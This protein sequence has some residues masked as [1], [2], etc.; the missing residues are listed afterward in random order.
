MIRVFKVCVFVSGTQQRR[1]PLQRLR[2]P[3][4][5][6]LNQKVLLPLFHNFFFRQQI[7]PS[8]TDVF[9]PLQFLNSVYLYIYIKCFRSLQSQWEVKNVFIQ[10]SYKEQQGQVAKRPGLSQGLS[11]E[12]FS[13][14]PL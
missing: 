13:S 7:S 11:P 2:T 1:K 12:Q 9:F 10:E 3:S 8:T 5:K 14:G 4:R 6:K